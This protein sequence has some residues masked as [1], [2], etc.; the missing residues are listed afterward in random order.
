M[1]SMVVI[2]WIVFFLHS[3][4]ECSRVLQILCCCLY[5]RMSVTKLNSTAVLK[6]AATYKIAVGI[7]VQGSKKIC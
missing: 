6:S 5:R 3:D 4:F 2:L 1:A 7:H